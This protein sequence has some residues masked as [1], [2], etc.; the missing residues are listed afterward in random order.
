MSVYMIKATDQLAASLQLSTRLVWGEGSWAR[1]SRCLSVPMVKL[2]RTEAEARERERTG[3]RCCSDCRGVQNHF[4]EY[5]EP[6]LDEV[7][8]ETGYHERRIRA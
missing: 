2:Y 7:P 1:V 4:T 3:K 8:V 6:L 5:I